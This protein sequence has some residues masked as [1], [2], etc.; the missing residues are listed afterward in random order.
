M[1]ESDFSRSIERT[2]IWLKESYPH[3]IPERL[4]KGAERASDAVSEPDLA[5]GTALLVGI[6]SE[7]AD[8]L[9]GLHSHSEPIMELVQ[10]IIERGLD[11]D[12]SS[13]RFIPSR[14]ALSEVWQGSAASIP[15][16]LMADLGSWSINDGQKGVELKLGESVRIGRRPVLRTFSPGKVIA[17]P[18]LKREVWEHLKQFLN[19]ISKR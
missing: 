19:I 13:V 16:L 15:L 9:G 1:A 2:L 11:L 12:I 14:A 6:Q 7:S 17:N 4:L 5:A 10:G 8:D 3:G 18:A